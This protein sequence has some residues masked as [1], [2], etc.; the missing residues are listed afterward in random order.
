MFKRPL[1]LKSGKIII[2][3]LITKNLLTTY[4]VS[5]VLGTGESKINDLCTF[6]KDFI[7]IKN[8]YSEQQVL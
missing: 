5:S 8:C 4:Y 6:L 7:F 2:F 3:F 1:I